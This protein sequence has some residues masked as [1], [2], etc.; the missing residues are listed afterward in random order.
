MEHGSSPWLAARLGRWTPARLI[1]L[2]AVLGF[3]PV[4]LDAA[5]V[6]VSNLAVLE[7]TLSPVPY[8]V[9]ILDAAL[10]AVAA[11]VG[12]FL[13]LSGLLLYLRSRHPPGRSRAFRA[14][15]GGAAIN[16]AAGLQLGLLNFSLYLLPPE[17]LTLEFLRNVVLV[18]FL[19]S[20]V[21]GA[22]F[23]LA[24]LGMAAL[25]REAPAADSDARAVRVRMARGKS[26]YRRA[27]SAR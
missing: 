24:F 1:V 12:W 10:L 18:L 4:V 16:L 19:S 8:A 6:L 9:V 21:A 23:L 11:P 17:L 26:I 5:V 25:A 27:P 15:F 20:V 14:G 13:A 2:G 3:G 22:G 7:G